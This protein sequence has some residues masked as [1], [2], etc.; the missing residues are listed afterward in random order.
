MQTETQSQFSTNATI[1][2]YSVLSLVNNSAFEIGNNI[3]Q[4]MLI[5]LSPNASPI[6]SVSAPYSGQR[7]METMPVEVMY[8]VTDDTASLSDIVMSWKIFGAQSQLVSEGVLSDTGSS[9]NITNV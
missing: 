2:A 6:A 9:F 5:S 7:F 1:E 3:N 8:T 4:Q